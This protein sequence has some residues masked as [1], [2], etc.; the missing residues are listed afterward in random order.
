MPL[1]LAERDIA[2]DY[3]ISNAGDP[4]YLAL[5]RVVATSS[6][7]GSTITE[8]AYPAYARVSV[9]TA[10]WNASV[11]GVKTNLNAITF[12]TADV[13]DDAVGWALCDDATTGL[14][15]AYAPLSPAAPITVG[16]I[17]RFTP[18]SLGIT[19]DDDS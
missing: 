3:I 7:D 6:D 11:D 5:L 15:V 8:V 9:A 18:G 4:L 12:A 17:P 19:L 14:I 2:L 16:D 1:A 10:D 13:D